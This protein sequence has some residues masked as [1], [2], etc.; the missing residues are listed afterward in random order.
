MPRVLCI[1][2]ELQLT[3]ADVRNAAHD[4]SCVLTTYKVDYH[5]LASAAHTSRFY[6]IPGGGGEGAENDGQ[7]NL[8]HNSAGHET[9]LEATNVCG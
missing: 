3:A 1:I 9:S 5:S 7:E 6:K 4:V 2:I 8:G